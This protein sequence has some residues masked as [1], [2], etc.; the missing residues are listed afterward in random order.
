MKKFSWKIITALGVAIVLVTAAIHHALKPPP[1]APTQATPLDSEA[2]KAPPDL[3]ML[4]ERIQAM[5][6]RQ[7]TPEELEEEKQYNR[8]KALALSDDQHD[9]DPNKRIVAV[10]QLGAYPSAEAEDLLIQALAQDGDASVRK[11]AAQTLDTLDNPSLRA[12]DALLQ[13]IEDDAVEVQQASL[14]TLEKWLNDDADKARHARLVSALRHAARSQHLAEDSRQYLQELLE[15][16]E[17][18]AEEK[19]RVHGSSPASNHAAERVNSEGEPL[20]A[21]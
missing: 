19:P 10:E 20:P 9:P 5:A 17:T 7:P 16:L 13:A 12:I 1:S 18:D 21:E 6:Y 3:S 15:P 4:A 8:E 14:L 2:A 11:M